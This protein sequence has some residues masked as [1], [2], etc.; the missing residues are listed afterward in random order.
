MDEKE[1]NKLIAIRQIYDSAL[2]ICDPVE[3]SLRQRDLLYALAD[4]IIQPL[5][6]YEFAERYKLPDHNFKVFPMEED[7]TQPS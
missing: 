7:E 6:E 2:S 4:Y 5:Q 3:Y 1:L